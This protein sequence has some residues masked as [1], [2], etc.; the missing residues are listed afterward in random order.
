M[1]L[2]AACLMSYLFTSGYPMKKDLVSSYLSRAPYLLLI[3]A[4]FFWSANF[5][6][7]RAVRADIPPIALAFYRWVLATIIVTPFALP[8]VKR[9]W[10]VIKENKLILLFLSITGIASFNTLVYLGLQ[11]TVAINALLLQSMIPVV[12]VAITFL[13]F[14]EKISFIQLVGICLS[15]LGVLTI[16]SKG[17]LE[18]ILGL[19]LNRGD[20]LVFIAVIG[21]GMYS[22]GLRKRPAIHPMSFIFVTFLTGVI[23]LSP[24][25]LY[26][27]QFIRTIQ[28]DVATAMAV[29]YVGIF[30]SI[31]SYLCYN[32]GVELVGPS[33]AG[34]FIHLM[35]VFGSIMAILFLGETLHLYHILG[36]IG[37]GCGI[38]LTTRFGLKK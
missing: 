16:I 21:Y 3:L 12:I 24:V 25:Y 5:I 19:T 36:I 15:L 9:D 20:I 13:V 18:T 35:P 29:A 26:E 8:H 17:H 28:F 31:V 34:M 2:A 23:C 11:L 4:V 33:R 37:I 7:G 6:V 10:S 1:Y 38:Y 32:R 30:P 14:R 27:H 22:V